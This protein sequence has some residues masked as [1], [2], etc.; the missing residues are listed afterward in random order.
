MGDDR[1]GHEEDC[2]D[3]EGGGR[4]GRERGDAQGES[5]FLHRVVDRRGL[6]HAMGGHGGNHGFGDERERHSDADACEEHR[7]QHGAQFAS[8]RGERDRGDRC[9]DEAAHDGGHHSSGVRL[10][11]AAQ[12]SKEFVHTAAVAGSEAGGL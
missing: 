2:S 10:V 4:S 5:D 11:L 6:A 7:T 9:G 1:A 3:G 8:E 12:V